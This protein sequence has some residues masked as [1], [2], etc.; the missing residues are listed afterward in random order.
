MLQGKSD[1]CLQ[2]KSVSSKSCFKYSTVQWISICMSIISGINQIET[3][4]SGQK[5]IFLH[6]AN[7][8]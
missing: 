4:N 3:L 6:F 8:D 2:V 1:L 7:M 5:F